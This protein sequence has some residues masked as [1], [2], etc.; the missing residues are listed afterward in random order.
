MQCRAAFELLDEAVLI[1]VEDLWH[2]H[3]PFA[4][5]LAP[6]NLVHDFLLFLERRLDDQLFNIADL[7][8]ELDDLD[9]LVTALTAVFHLI[10]FGGPAPLVCLLE[11]SLIVKPAR[12]CGHKP[13]LCKARARD[14]RPV[15]K[16]LDVG[17]VPV[18]KV[19]IC[20]RAG[21]GRM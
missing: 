6:H 20:V 18:G 9:F 15:L 17:H 14:T 7:V 1:V 10:D 21:S 12:P 3:L 2:R 13:T 16:Y 11:C 5:E 19:V 8:L 4:R